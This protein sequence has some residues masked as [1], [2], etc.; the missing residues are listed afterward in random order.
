[1][2]THSFAA[3]GDRNISGEVKN[4]VTKLYD[5]KDFYW[6]E[7]PDSSLGWLVFREPPTKSGGPRTNPSLFGCSS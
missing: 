5:K 4:K 1:M 7:C 6:V 3:D 2:G